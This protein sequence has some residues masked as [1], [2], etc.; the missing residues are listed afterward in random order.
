MKLAI[1]TYDKLP[2]GVDDDHILFNEIKQLGIELSI[3]PWNTQVNWSDYDACLLR[4]VWDYHEQ[5]SEFSQ[6]LKHVS[7]TSRLLN[8]RAI[9]EW[10]SSKVYLRD[11][12][13]FGVTIAPTVWLKK[14]QLFNLE[15]WAS[16]QSS[17]QFFLKPIV[18]A[19]SSGTCRFSHDAAGLTQAK[20]HLSAWQPQMDMMLQPYLKSVE[21]FGETS[22]IYFNGSFSHA[23]RKIPVAGDFRVQDTFG[24]SDVSYQPNAAEL[25]LA[26]A[27]L[28]YITQ[29]Y[30][31]P[32]Y[33]RFDFLHEADGSVY[34]NEAEL[35]E[36]SLFFNHDPNA[37]TRFAQAIHASLLS[38]Q[39]D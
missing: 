36:P 32:L 14:G 25:A 9:I 16:N 15:D 30:Q 31:L 29:R 4:S 13:A 23:V 12:A 2:N 18:G 6:W 22:A 8:P 21:T 37:A 35:I 38:D 11:L 27:S 39:S 26:K 20:Q 24:A 28:Q 34:L 7:N 3:V 10:N 19:D 33:A 1:V 5:F 17:S